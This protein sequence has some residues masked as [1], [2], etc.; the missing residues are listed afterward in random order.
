M[1]A[2]DKNPMVATYAGALEQYDRVYS[3]K[4]NVAC[5]IRP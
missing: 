3:F 4:I 1:F 2:S 5:H